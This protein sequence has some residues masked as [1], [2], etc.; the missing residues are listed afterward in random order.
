MDITRYVVQNMK[1]GKNY[2]SEKDIDK[3]AGVEP[4]DQCPIFRVLDGPHE[5]SVDRVSE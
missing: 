2:H 4:S 5:K 1:P 3:P